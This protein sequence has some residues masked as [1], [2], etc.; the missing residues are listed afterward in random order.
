M[1]PDP[2]PPAQG[3]TPCYDFQEHP[4]W[5]KKH[6]RGPVRWDAWCSMC[7]V[8]LEDQP[9]GTGMTLQGNGVTLGYVT[10]AIN[11]VGITFRSDQRII[12]C[13]KCCPQIL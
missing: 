9:L 13:S 3:P 5:Q 8:R 6:V 12:V 4:D 10:R 11:F 1:N 7:G 2:N